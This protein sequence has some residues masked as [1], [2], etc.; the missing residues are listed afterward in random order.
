MQNAL[1]SRCAYTSLSV[2]FNCLTI[3]KENKDLKWSL[4]H[5]YKNGII[6]FILDIDS[7]EQHEADRA[8]ATLRPFELFQ[9]VD[10]AIRI[11]RESICSQF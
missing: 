9:S 4:I 11:Y 10:G 5:I 2:K 6:Y 7:D 1:Q 3:Q 8:A